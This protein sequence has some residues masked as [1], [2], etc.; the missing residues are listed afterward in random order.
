MPI[1]DA[2]VSFINRVN[3]FFLPAF[4]VLIGTIIWSSRRA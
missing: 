4:F 2:Q 3:W 1:L